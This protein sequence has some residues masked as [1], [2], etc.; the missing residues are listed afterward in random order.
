M[1]AI[2]AIA[3]LV[4]GTLKDLGRF[5][6]T[7]LMFPLTNYPGF[8]QLLKQKRLALNSGYAMQWNLQ[9]DTNNGATPVGLNEVDNVNIVDTMGSATEPIR[10]VTNNWAIDEREI[11]ANSGEAQVFDLVKSRRAACW[12]DLVKKIEGYIW[13][14][15][16]STDAK[17]PR[18]LL[19]YIA[20]DTSSATGAF[21]SGLP[22]TFAQAS[23]GFTTIAGVDPAVTTQWQNWAGA[24]TNVSKTDLIRN[25][26]QAMVKT[27]FE[28]PI[29][30]PE[31]TTAPD[32][33][34]YTDYGVLQT[35][36]EL[37]EAQ[38]QNLGK[39]VAS[40][41]GVATFRR[42]PIRY[43][44]TLD[45]HTKSPVIGVN[46]GACKFRYLKGEFFRE[47]MRKAPLQHRTVQHFVDLT[48][49]LQMYDRRRQWIFQTA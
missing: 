4:A 40:M 14:C 6:W 12:G 3:D 22:V 29:D 49:G 44:P 23:S 30:V 43:V 10:N 36:E 42:H 33:G 47:E 9:L 13:G 24:Y 26:R 27:D 41:D 16:L 7:E 34:I 25:M 21:T 11:T 35:I 39:D 28:C 48:Y 15:P 31:Y 19:Y 8:T 2:E 1:P 45:S 32:Y 37:L 5:K 17:T 20:K 38:N 46:W 18:G